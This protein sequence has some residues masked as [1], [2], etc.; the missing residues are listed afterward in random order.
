M[1]IVA[2]DIGYQI[3]ESAKQARFAC[4]PSK[5]TFLVFF[6]LTFESYTQE[7]ANDFGLTNLGK[8]VT[9]DS[10]LPGDICTGPWRHWWN[11]RAYRYAWC[12]YS[13]LGYSPIMQTVSLILMRHH[14]QP[15]R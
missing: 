14:T 12:L 11:W 8:G 3:Q 7:G 13:G 4:E 9:V 2:G 10:A 15:Q 5:R 1:G 6:Y